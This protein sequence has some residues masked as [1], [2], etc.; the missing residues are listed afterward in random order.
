M[1][2]LKYI[3][4]QQ[5]VKYSL[6]MKTILWVVKMETKENQLL[7][8]VEIGDIFSKAF[9]KITT[10]YHLLVGIENIKTE[11]RYK[12]FKVNL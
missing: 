11:G 7:Q 2:G 4:L 3:Q 8:Y 10:I 1:Y 5:Y 9:L 12:Y 6:N